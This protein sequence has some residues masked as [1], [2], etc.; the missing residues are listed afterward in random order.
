[1][2]KLQI[3]LASVILMFA[4]IGTAVSQS[5][6][7]KVM[8]TNG[9]PTIQKENSNNWESIKLGAKVNP[10]DQIKL[11]KN[12]YI[13]LVHKS[14]KTIELKKSGTYK[15]ADLSKQV[16]SSKSSVASKFADYLLDEVGGD[17]AL[18]A[19]GNYR[20]NMGVTG[21]VTRDIPDQPFIKKDGLRLNSPRKVNLLSSVFTFKWISADNKTDY[22]FILTDRF[23]RP[24]MTKFVKGNSITLNADELKLDKNTYYFW[25]IKVKDDDK[26]KSEDA[27]FLL[28]STDK[29]KAIQDTV[30][31]INEEVGDPD[32]PTAKLILAAFY[33][34]NY[35]IDEALR[36][37]KEAMTLAPDVDLYK[38]L[39]QRFLLKINV[40]DEK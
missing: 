18:L 6:Q 19:E 3:S 26:S 5:Y 11:S 21:S 4:L 38:K 12:S 9:N 1:M 25:K 34:Q 10:K 14:G 32:S 23:D 40:E 33:E 35:I 7:F 16:N 15:V 17:E 39:Y 8:A 29:V 27:C 31:T 24:V 30:K 37:Y 20:D 22:E 2:K 28:L 36:S 13:S